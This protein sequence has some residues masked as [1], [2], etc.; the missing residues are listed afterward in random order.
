[1]E[2]KIR[3]L[4]KRFR[5][6][7]NGVTSSYMRDKGLN[8]KLNFGV[9]LPTIKQIAKK[10]TGDIELAERL[11]TENVRESIIVATLIY[12]LESISL[13]KAREMASRIE[14]LEIAEQFSMNIFSK[15]PQAETLVIE[16][17]NSDSK[18][19]RVVGSITLVRLLMQGVELSH[20]N[21]S[22]IIENLCATLQREP[23]ETE[24]FTAMNA[25]KRVGR[26]GESIRAQIIDRMSQNESERNI[27]IKAELQAEFAYYA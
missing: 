25:I 20:E 17:L 4:K 12:P 26:L 2:D 22:S 18:M 7:M 8:Y 9:A 10:Y 21:L 11:L 14:H 23:N 13:D 19:L 27:E 5:L 15:L 24:F 1:M 6:A 16:W 3:E